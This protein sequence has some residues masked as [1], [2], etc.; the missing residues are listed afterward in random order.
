MTDDSDRMPRV[1][2]EP[3]PTGEGNVPRHMAT[4]C[5]WSNG[6]EEV[7]LPEHS[8][9][10]HA[11]VEHVDA[12]LEPA[13]AASPDAVGTPSEGERL[14]PDA[15]SA[16][17]PGD[18]APSQALDEQL[19]TIE[20]AP[21]PKE[22]GDA[23]DDGNALGPDAT[24]AV[25]AAD[26]RAPKIEQGWAVD[27]GTGTLPGGRGF[28]HLL[29]AGIIA[30]LVAILGSSL[31]LTSCFGLFSDP[32]V[33][34]VVGLDAASA[35]AELESQ[36]YDVEVSEQVTQSSE[37]AGRVLATEPTAGSALPS[38]GDVT[39]K[40]G[41]SPEVTQAVPDLVGLSLDDAVTAL[42][43]TK[44]FVKDDV[45]FAYSDTVAAGKVISQG[46]EA[47]AMEVMGTKVDLVVSDGPNPDAGDTSDFADDNEQS[48]VSIPDLRGMTVAK[49]T[50]LLRGMGLEV[51]RGEAVL[52]DDFVNGTV[53]AVEP[54]TDS[55]VAV[56]STV[57]IHE[58]Q[59]KA[60]TAN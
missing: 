41:K 26:V 4:S 6:Q 39:L 30:V 22:D 9:A 59:P 20:A 45:T 52:T 36:G 14:E 1:E 50:V 3:S 57:T 51:A 35:Q 53:A 60:G 7:V 19:P 46:P 56:G 37:D 5:P 54:P 48:S 15:T 17:A 43:Q 18:A 55:V 10:E 44:F 38:G 29:V 13:G 11:R 40:V 34:N 21:T 49:A 31:I 23:V 28:P 25:K 8:A 12:A 58:A 33:L 32:E 24:G 2:D 16:V 47:G 42:A 27:K